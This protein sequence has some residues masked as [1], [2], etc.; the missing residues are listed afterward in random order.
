MSKIS[1]SL[2]ISASLVEGLDSSSMSSLFSSED[3][4]LSLGRG[5]FSTH[6]FHLSGMSLGSVLSD[7]SNSFLVSGKYS[8]VLLVLIIHLYSELS[9]RSGFHLVHLGVMSS[10]GFSSLDASSVNS[11]SFL[12]GCKSGLSLN[13]LSDSQGLESFHL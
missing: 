3:L 6:G 10:L 4:G 11:Y 12:V 8:L 9:K 2:F 13:G 5:S 1:D 7:V